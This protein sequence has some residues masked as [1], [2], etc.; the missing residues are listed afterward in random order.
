M[1]SHWVVIRLKLES[2]QF[3]ILLAAEYNAV[4]MVPSKLDTPDRRV[5][6]MG[7]RDAI[8]GLDR[9]SENDSVET[10]ELIEIFVFRVN[11]FF[12][13]QLRALVSNSFS[14]GSFFEEF[15]APGTPGGGGGSVLVVFRPGGGGGTLVPFL[16]FLAGGAPEP[17]L[18]SPGGGPVGG[19]GYTTFLFSDD[20]SSVRFGGFGGGLGGIT[21][22]Q[23]IG[24]F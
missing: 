5:V 4:V 13:N 18:E 20:F 24:N 7:K 19:G 3:W 15:I 21:K 11:V 16:G 1:A 10:V 22:R 17:P 8:L 23:N 14:R 12:C 6:K 2:R 9:V